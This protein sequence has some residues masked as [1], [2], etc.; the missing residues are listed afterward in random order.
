MLLTE[1]RIVNRREVIGRAPLLPE[2]V[3]SP[4]KRATPD[5][6]TDMSVTPD[7]SQDDPIAL[8]RA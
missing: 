7:A 6:P 1:G 4:D 5:F 2:L 8:Q 3:H